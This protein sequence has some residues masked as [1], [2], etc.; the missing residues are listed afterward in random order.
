MTVDLNRDRP[1]PDLKQLLEAAEANAKT[2]F[3]IEFLEQGLP[4]AKCSLRKMA[5]SGTPGAT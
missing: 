1:D 4:I 3:E 2:D 5:R